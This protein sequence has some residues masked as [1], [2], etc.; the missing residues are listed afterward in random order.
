MQCGMRAGDLIL[1]HGALYFRVFGLNWPHRMRNMT[2]RFS[3][4]AAIEPRSSAFQGAFVVITKSSRKTEFSL[5][6]NVGIP[7]PGGRKE[8]DGWV[9][10]ITVQ[11]NLWEATGA[12]ETE[13]DE[14]WLSAEPSRLFRTSFRVALGASLVISAVMIVVGIDPL[15]ASIPPLTVMAL[16][17]LVSIAV[18]TG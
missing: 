17:S 7:L 14:Q 15:G 9:D 2:F 6:P 11:M 12:T 5:A 13:V 16:W 3:D 4:I 8:R 1:T 18:N 10:A